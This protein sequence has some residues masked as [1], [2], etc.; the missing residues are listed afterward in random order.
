MCTAR[1]QKYLPQPVGRCPVYARAPLVAAWGADGRVVIR[2]WAGALEGPLEVR[3][4]GAGGLR[5][6][7]PAGRRG[8]SPGN[9]LAS[10]DGGARWSAAPGSGLWLGWVLEGAER[11]LGWPADAAVRLVA[12][13]G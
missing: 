6:A 2:W 11:L 1:R 9:G 10:S 5:G 13:D 8:V 7:L 3:A 12:L 4:D